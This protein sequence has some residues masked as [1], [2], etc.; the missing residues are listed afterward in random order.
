[1][2]AS[3]PMEL[4]GDIQHVAQRGFFLN[5]DRLSLPQGE[6]VE[7]ALPS[8]APTLPPGME[9]GWYVYSRP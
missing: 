4:L 5:S 1:M 3:S 6:V 2:E 8:L 7:E 9:S